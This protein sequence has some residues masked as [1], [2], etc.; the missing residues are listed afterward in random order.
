MMRELIPPDI[1]K[2]LLYNHPPGYSEKS[3]SFSFSQMI[4][5]ALTVL[6]PA[7]RRSWAKDSIGTIPYQQ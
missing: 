3:S 7:G 4:L 6:S 1:M 2:V 5:I